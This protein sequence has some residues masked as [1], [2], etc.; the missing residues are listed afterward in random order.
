MRRKRAIRSDLPDAIKADIVPNK[1]AVRQSL[2]HVA[3]IKEAQIYLVYISQTTYLFCSYFL[4][5]LFSVKGCKVYSQY[6]DYPLSIIRT[7][8]LKRLV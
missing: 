6:V 8:F 5:I 7:L 2:S 1:V 3:T 4:S